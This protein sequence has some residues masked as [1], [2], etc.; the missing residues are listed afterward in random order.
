M[1]DN[2]NQQPLNPVHMQV[3]LQEAQVLIQLQL[4]RAQQLA[5]ELHEARQ[6][7]AV[8]SQQLAEEQSKSNGTDSKLGDVQRTK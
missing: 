1:A 7:I 8:L 2:Q 6:T 3:A 5:I 4:S